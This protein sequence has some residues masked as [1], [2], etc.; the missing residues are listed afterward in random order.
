MHSPCADASMIDTRVYFCMSRGVTSVHV[1]PLLRVSQTRP[2]SVPA[3]RN[4]AR[5]GDSAMVKTTP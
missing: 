4:P 3:H 2:S 5:T 1:V